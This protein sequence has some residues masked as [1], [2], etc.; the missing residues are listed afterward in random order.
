MVLRVARPTDNLAKLVEQY[1][2]GLEL[3]E[4][5]SFY[6]HDGFDGVILGKPNSYYHLEFTHHKDSKAGKAPTKDN[7]I[8]FYIPDI[9]EWKNRCDSMVKSGFTSVNSFNPYWDI[10]GKTFEDIDGYRIVLANYE[11]TK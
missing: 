7:L 3:E 8:V 4:L 1:K 11:W 2:K 10:E 9:T 6:N 5:S